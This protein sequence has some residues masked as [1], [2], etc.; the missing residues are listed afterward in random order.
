MEDFEV[1]VLDVET[2]LMMEMRERLSN[3][4]LTL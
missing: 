4:S 3:G 1:T 2:K